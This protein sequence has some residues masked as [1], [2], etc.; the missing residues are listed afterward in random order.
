[1]GGAKVDNEIKTQF[2]DLVGKARASE[3]TTWAEQPQG[4]LALIILLDQFPRNIFRGSPLS[5]SSDS[6][7]VEVA[8][9]AIAKGFDREVTHLQQPFFYLPLMHSEN[10]LSQ[11][12]AL[13][14]YDN[15][16]HRCEPD[17]MPKEY[18]ERSTEYSRL[19]RDV[20]M[21]FG[22]FPSRNEVLGRI[23][24]LEEMQ[25]LEEHPSG[26]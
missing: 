25:Y 24:T 3:L 9:E 6:I 4:A 16:C 8:T 15:L 17:S 22:R 10:L 1:M 12:A 21:R 7:A 5:Y 2:G 13:S 20:I 18:A 11:V 26:F 19:H 23:S 14:L